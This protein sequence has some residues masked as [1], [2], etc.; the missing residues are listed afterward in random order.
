VV[1]ARET[2]AAEPGGFFLSAGKGLSAGFC[3]NIAFRE[4]TL[5][6]MGMRLR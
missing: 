5:L 6:P 1:D 4:E 2:P 3:S